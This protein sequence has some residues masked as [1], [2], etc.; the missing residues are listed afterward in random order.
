MRIPTNSAAE[1]SSKLQEDNRLLAV[2]ILWE[3]DEIAKNEETILAL[4]P[5]SEWAEEPTFGP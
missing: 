5:V 1:L 3:Q 4:E 2:K